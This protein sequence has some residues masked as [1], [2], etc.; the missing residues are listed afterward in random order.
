MAAC[1]ITSLYQ[2]GR[3]DSI[4]R[5]VW[6]M[7]AKIY[8]RQR[9]DKDTT[10]SLE[11]GADVNTAAEPAVDALLPPFGND[12]RK[13]ATATE[14]E[15]A[16]D[17]TSNSMPFISFN[18]SKR[19][20][21]T[22]L[23]LALERYDDP[24]VM[25]HVLAWMVFLNHIVRYERAKHL[26]ETDFP[27]QSLIKALNILY[28][29]DSYEATAFCGADIDDK[30]RY[31]Q[32]ERPLPEEFDLLGFEWAQNYMQNEWF[33]EKPIDT[34]ERSQESDS[35]EKTRKQR[36]LW[37]AVKLSAVKQNDWITFDP[38]SKSFSIHPSLKSRTDILYKQTFDDTKARNE[39]SKE[40]IVQDGDCYEE[41]QS[42]VEMNADGYVMVEH[43]PLSEGVKKL[44]HREQE[45]KAQIAAQALRATAKPE[46][47]A[48]VSKTALITRGP[49]IMNPTYTVFILDTNLL[50]S[51]L[52]TFSLL[53]SRGW[54]IIIPNAG[55][56]PCNPL[57]E[58]IV[59]T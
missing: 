27:F 13:I 35:M 43:E 2:Y 29:N 38:S 48:E 23:A 50:I 12:Q 59:L 11:N 10:L 37:L 16:T 53:V 49:E 17:G 51:H 22:V 26:V 3:G 5:E 41:S 25:P 6:K 14:L 46:A 9:V 20:A 44:K 40:K 45:L 55:R 57:F 8:G 31:V 7:D 42:D 32:G 28:G 47:I 24:N 58:I 21:Y 19:L 39:I 1:N 36:I 34:E 15:N 52:D 18:A 56:V 30:L 54:P 4:L 33:T